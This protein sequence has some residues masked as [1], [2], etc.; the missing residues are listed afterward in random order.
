MN[1]LVKLWRNFKWGIKPPGQDDLPDII[2]VISSSKNRG[3]K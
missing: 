1:W 2:P 3:T